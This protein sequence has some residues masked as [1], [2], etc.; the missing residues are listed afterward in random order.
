MAE[1]NLK[2]GEEKRNLLH[3]SK[4][5]IRY[6]QQ[7]VFRKGYTVDGQRRET[8]EF[9][10]RVRHSGERDFFPLATPNRAAAAAKARNIYL[11]L[12]ANGWEQTLIKYK[13]QSQLPPSADTTTSVG[14]FL[15]AV[16]SVKT[17]RSTIEGYATAF[18]KIVAD[19]FGLSDDNSK[20]DFHSGGRAKWVEKIHAIALGKIT[21]A[22]VNE[23]KQSF[24]SSASE[25]PLMLRKAR[26]SVNSILRR[27]R[28]LFSPKLLR[29]ITIA[30]P[31]LSRSTASNSSRARA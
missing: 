16:I 22:R 31:P 1:V 24:I 27:A 29:Q 23:W 12:L 6:W 2:S 9:Y 13:P 10:A 8:K 5:D 7:S 30:L 3:F 4:S 17:D 26:I 21:P 25:N 15:D 28:S 11:F 19:I 18:R 14:T 20:F